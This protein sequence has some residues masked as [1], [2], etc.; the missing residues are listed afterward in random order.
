MFLE[1]VKNGEEVKEI[2]NGCKKYYNGYHN[3]LVRKYT[4]AV[5]KEKELKNSPVVKKYEDLG[6]KKDITSY[7]Y[8]KMDCSKYEIQKQAA[9]LAKELNYKEC[10]PQKVNLYEL[11]EY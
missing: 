11:S 2:E 3:N 9:S 5:N 10:T 8:T 4:N 7:P 6:F 1:F